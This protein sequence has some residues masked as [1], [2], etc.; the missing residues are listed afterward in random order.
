MLSPEHENRVRSAI[1]MAA[2]KLFGGER[3]VYEANEALIDSLPYFFAQLEDM[4]E[5]AESEET[6]FVMI[7][8][9]FTGI[10]LHTSEK[11]RVVCCWYAAGPSE[12]TVREVESKKFRNAYWEDEEHH[13]ELGHGCWILSDD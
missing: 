4:K 7:G 1:S 2:T 3:S 11:I 10:D 8:Q 13:P 12:L 9:E 6:P 5:D